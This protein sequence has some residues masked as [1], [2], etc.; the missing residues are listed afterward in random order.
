MT[1]RSILSTVALAG[2][3]AGTAYAHS[4]SPGVATLDDA[5]PMP[6]GDALIQT[7]SSPDSSMEGGAFD[8][9]ASTAETIDR[10]VVEGQVAAV[11]HGSGR[12]V[13]D[14]DDG[15]IGLVTS[16]DELEGVEVGDVVRVSFLAD[17]SD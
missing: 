13:L 1:F 9:V 16:P 15:L 17:E 12:F 2:A 3:L 10:D 5:L 6:Y 7:E 4:T 14:T 8:W 11:E